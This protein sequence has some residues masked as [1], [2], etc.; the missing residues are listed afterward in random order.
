M[1]LSDTELELLEAHLDGE[2]PPVEV[3]AVRQRL[4]TDPEFREALETLSGE[5]AARGLFF[6]ACE[7]SEASVNRLVDSVQ[8]KVDNQWQWSSWFSKLRPLTAAAACILV[9][10][11]IGRVNG[12]NEITTAPTQVAT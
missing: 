7:P 2:L 6:Q 10:V 1:A 9:G 11:M 12:R 5:R 3:G 8:R 4:E